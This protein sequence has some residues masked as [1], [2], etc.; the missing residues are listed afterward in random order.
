MLTI[1]QDDKNYI[2]DGSIAISSCCRICHEEEDVES[3]KKLEAP[4]ACSGTVKF[5][6]RE[7]IQRWCNEKGD[8]TCEIC[9]QNYGPGYT[10]PPPRPKK[11]HPT[12]DDDEDDVDDD[13]VVDIRGRRLRGGEDIVIITTGNNTTTLLDDNDELYTECSSAADR[14]ASCCRTVALI[15]TALLLIQHLHAVLAEGE[16]RHYPFSLPTVLVLRAFGI[17][18][19]MFMIIRTISAIQHSIQR[20]R[21]FNDSVEVVFRYRSG[22]HEQQLLHTA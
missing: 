4:C 21:R 17:L 7:C 22:D 20:H 8:T 14:T 6:H 3:C 1:D 10:A 13:D 9:L 12:D 2:E 18:L 5:A 16:A 19:P 15:L 11:C